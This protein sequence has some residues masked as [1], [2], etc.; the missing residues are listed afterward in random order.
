MSSLACVLA[1]AIWIQSGTAPAALT[2]SDCLTDKEKT[3][4]SHQSGIDGRIKVYRTISERLHLAIE[5]NTGKQNFDGVT[6]LISCWK[7]LLTSSLQ[8]IEANIN[9]KKKSGAL[10]NY[11]IQLRKSIVD[12]K[13]VRLKLPLPQQDDMEAWLT[14]AD[15]THKRAVDILFQ[16]DSQKK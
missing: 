6:P 11:E 5:G 14:Q 15:E 9:R 16:R 8:D 4:L 1:I 7:Q 13:D 3:E 2:G 12:M 10:I